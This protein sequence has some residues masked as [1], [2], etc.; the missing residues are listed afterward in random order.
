MKQRAWE[1]RWQL[2]LGVNVAVLVGDLIFKITL[3]PYV[4]YLHLLADYHFGFTKRAL[5]AELVSL[6]IDKVPLWL[7]YALGGTV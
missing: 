1:N 3:K 4:P 6:F 2:M 5:I 7:V